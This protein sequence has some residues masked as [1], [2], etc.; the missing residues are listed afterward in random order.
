MAKFPS[1]PED[2]STDFLTEA[3]GS[4][5]ASF[6]I[7]QIGIGVGLLGRLYRLKLSSQGGPATVI[8]KFP[9]LDQGARMNVVE[10]LRFYEKEV[11]YYREFGDSSAIPTA[12]AYFAEHDPATGDFLLVLEDFGDRRMEDQIAGC[13]NDDATAAVDA[14]IDLHSTWWNSDAFPDW[15]PSYSD[16]P[17]PQVIAGMYK[18]S[19]PHAVEVFEGHFS[20]KW[21]DYGERYPD[22][23]PWFMDN[24]AGEPLS[25][26]H[27]DYRLDNL[28]FATSADHPP[29]SVVDWQICFRGRPGYD[30]AYFVSQSIETDHRRECEDKL[31]TRYLEGLAKRG[32]NYD[33]G[34]LLEDYK[35]TVAYCFIYAVV[36]AGQI[37]MSN[38]RQRDLVLGIGDRAIQAMEDNDVLAILPS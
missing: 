7:E 30:L 8:A 14:L 25:L 27:G 37:E 13:G 1:Q 2:L 18:Q 6:E 23:V 19:W 17:Y 9:T 20:Q 28:F 5:V 24:L 29:L 34:Q 10:P 4:N 36:T 22:L 21:L 38:D 11:R 3:V 15:L 35:R 16:P 26:C 31:R 12:H 32:A 33:E